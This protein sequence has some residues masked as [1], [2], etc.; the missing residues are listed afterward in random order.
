MSDT[1]ILQRSP[2]LESRLHPGWFA[3]R[4][5]YQQLVLPGG[6]VDVLVNVEDIVGVVLRLDAREAVVVIAIGGADAVLSFVHHEVDVCATSGVGMGRLPVADAPV[7]DQAGLG[8]PGRRLWD[9][10]V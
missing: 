10:S 5:R 7:A 1:K 4:H 3:T 6:G 9:D 2:N 8:V